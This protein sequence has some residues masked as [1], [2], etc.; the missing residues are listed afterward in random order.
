MESDKEALEL[1][2][3]KI[4]VPIVVDVKVGDHW[5]DAKEYEVKK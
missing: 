3:C 1:F 5:G 2:D 4:T